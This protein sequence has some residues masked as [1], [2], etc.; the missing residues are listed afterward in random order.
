MLQAVMGVY[1]VEVRYLRLIVCLAHPVFV[2][3][4]LCMSVSDACRVFLAVH[5]DSQFNL[6]HLT[7]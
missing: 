1:R 3:V 5:S 4:G 6:I 2:C 7:N